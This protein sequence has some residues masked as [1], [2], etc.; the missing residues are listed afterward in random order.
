MLSIEMPEVLI[1]QRP[2][3][4]W[5]D[6]AS[7]HLRAHRAERALVGACEYGQKLWLTLDAQRAYLCRVGEAD[8]PQ[9]RNGDEWAD[10]AAQFIAVSD[11]IAGPHGDS[12]S[13]AS[14]ATRIAREHGVELTHEPGSPVIHA[15]AQ[16]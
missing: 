3:A 10:W 8:G 16:H 11:A 13:G 15:D 2:G 1:A 6:D 12:G 7:D 9:L 4:L 5:D 14:E